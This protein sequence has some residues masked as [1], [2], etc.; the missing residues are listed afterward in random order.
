M[1]FEA[2]IM[3]KVQNVCLYLALSEGD[4]ESQ[5]PDLD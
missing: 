4:D 5:F 1:P 3:I 2:E